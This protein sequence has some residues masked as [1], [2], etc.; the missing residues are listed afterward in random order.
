MDLC[1]FLSDLYQFCPQAE[2]IL[3]N[4]LINYCIIPILLNGFLYDKKVFSFHQ[5]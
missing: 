1:Y 2:D 5:H 4:A 3:D